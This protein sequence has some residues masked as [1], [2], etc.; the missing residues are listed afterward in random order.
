MANILIIEDDEVFSEL[1]VMFMEDR[2]HQSQAAHTLSMARELLDKNEPDII[3]LDQELP[4]GLG[5]EFLQEIVANAFHPP[6]IMITGVSD[7][8]LVMQAMKLGAHDFIRKPVEDIELETTF[9]NA[10]KSHRLTRQVSAI[11]QADEYHVDMGQ[12]IGQSPAIIDI[13]KKIGSVS[14]S[15]APVLITGESGTGKEVIAH[16]LHHHSESSGLLLP[17]NCAA[18]AENLLESELFGHEKGSFTGAVAS[19]EGKFE[20]TVDGTLFLDE[21]GEM[22]MSLQAKLLRV[23]QEGSFERVGGTR[24]LYSNAR[25]I[26][27]TNRDL[28]AMIASGDFREDLFYRLNVVHIH[29]PPLRERMEDLPILIEHL[30]GKINM[31]QQSIIKYL[32]E[33]A[34]KAIKNYTWPGNIRE[35]ENVL[36]RAAILARS[37]TITASLLGLPEETITAMADDHEETE[38]LGLRLISI[39]E[40]EQEHIEKILQYTRWHK[41]KACK[42]LGISRPALERKIKKYHLINQI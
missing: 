32:A 23:L 19:K 35:L 21:L 11:K 42:I 30:I 1:L 29:L 37:D 14:S 34:W 13:C 5:I 16:A 6:V 38:Q 31:K 9:N 15:N 17:V 40:L 8:K 10:L 7:N 2:N 41:G 18:L 24:T 4:D 22:P 27:A 28:Q 33:D 20:Q 36:T 3:L 25:I 12:I 26:T 39:D